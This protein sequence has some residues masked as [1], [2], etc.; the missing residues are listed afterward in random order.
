MTIHISAAD[1][2]LPYEEGSAIYPI[3]GPVDLIL[4]TTPTPTKAELRM[5]IQRFENLAIDLGK[6]WGS[7]Q[8]IEPFVKAKARVQRE[9]D[10]LIDALPIEEG[11]ET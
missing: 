6:A 2:P 9:L 11:T 7:P 10:D 5:T 1:G 3:P 8:P 4:L